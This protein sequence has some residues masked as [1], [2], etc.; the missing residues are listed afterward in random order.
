MLEYINTELIPLMDKNI[1]P[2]TR[3]ASALKMF[4]YRLDKGSH[5]KNSKNYGCS[6]LIIHN[7]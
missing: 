4:G 2:Y 1:K 5:D 7:K 3:L 6:T